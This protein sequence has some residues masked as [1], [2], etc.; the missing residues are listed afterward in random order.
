MASSIELAAR[1]SA[2]V[3]I[4]QDMLAVINDPD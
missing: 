3:V 1:L 2:V 4:Q